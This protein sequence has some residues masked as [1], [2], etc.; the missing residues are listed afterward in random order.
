MIK[1]SAL[2]FT[3]FELLVVI[4]LIGL[5][6]LPL[7]TGGGFIGGAARIRANSDQL[8]SDMVLARS[9]AR[10]ARDRLNWGVRFATQN[11]YEIISGNDESLTVFAARS[12]DS[13]VSFQD[14][15]IVWFTSGIGETTDDHELF[16]VDR[17]GRKRKIVVY[18]SGLIE[19]F[20]L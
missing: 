8:Y 9:Y 7:L 4:A 2:G 3:I 5:L 20:E 18:Q 17:D 12:L 15:F 6:S 19:K 1:K 13:S 16:L 11:S 10:D 14:E